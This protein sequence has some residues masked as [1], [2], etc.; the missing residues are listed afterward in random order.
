MMSLAIID[1]R[2]HLGQ[3]VFLPAILGL[4][5]SFEWM[6]RWRILPA[7]LMMRRAQWQ[8]LAMRSR[9]RPA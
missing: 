7:G 9:R 3:Q 8:D 5:P 6:Y 1:L 2:H 4:K